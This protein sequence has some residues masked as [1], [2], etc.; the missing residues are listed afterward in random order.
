M[1]DSIPL[2]TRL[3][4]GVVTALVAAFVLAP[5]LVAVAVSVSDS[6]F[7]TFPPKGFTLSWYGQVLSDRNF[8]SAVLL[9][10]ELALAATA[11]SLLMGI[12]A[13]FALVRLPFA[14]A[15]LIRELLLTPLVFPVLISGLVL[16]KFFGS[17]G[18]HDTLPKLVIA[19]TLI[20]LP[21]VVRTVTA[22]LVL[23]D[24]SLEEAAMTLGCSPRQ[25]FF[26]VT[27][28][29]MAPGVAAG[30]LFAFMI[31]LDNYPVSMW[32]VDASQ[33]PV[34]VMLFQSMSRMFDPS[35]AAM[36]SLMIFVGAA[37]VWALEKLV[38]LRRAFSM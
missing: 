3:L 35:I 26:K 15:R 12:P 30:A 1:K 20:T 11:L 5:L 25:T 31:S 37:A 36:A 10:V 28:P 13:A 29:Q 9:S 6:P 19:H 17:I 18:I 38:G 32:F 21:Y 33:V 7:V 23:V 2:R 22:S 14:G 16:I 4:F 24:R 27:L 8:F 34:P